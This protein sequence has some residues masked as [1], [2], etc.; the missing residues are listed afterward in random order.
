MRE[1]NRAEEWFRAKHDELAQ[2][3]RASRGFSFDRPADALIIAARGT[4]QRPRSET[5]GFDAFL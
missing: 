1:K 4:R 3:A 2:T 5:R